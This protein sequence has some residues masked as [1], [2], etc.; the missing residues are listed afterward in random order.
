MRKIRLLGEI[1][2]CI[3]LCRFLLSL[4]KSPYD[5]AEEARMKCHYYEDEVCDFILFVSLS[6]SSSCLC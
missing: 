1:M 6:P 3:G 2:S 4:P 5:H